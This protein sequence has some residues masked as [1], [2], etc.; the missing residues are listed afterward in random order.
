VGV[1]NEDKVFDIENQFES[2]F[3]TPAKVM[4]GVYRDGDD[5]M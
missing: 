1:K 3:K 5:F 4:K 2:F